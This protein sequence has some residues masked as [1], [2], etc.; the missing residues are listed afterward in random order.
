MRPRPVIILGMHRSGTSCL[1]GSLEARGLYLGDVDRKP[2]TN[3]KGNREKMAL[4]TLNNDVLAGTGATWDRPPMG[5]VVW[6]REQQRRRDAICASF[7][8]GRV[9]GFKDPRTLLLIEGWLASLPEAWLIGTVRN[10]VA[11]ARSL[12]KRNGFPF[13]KSFDL[14]LAYNRRLLDLCR[15]REVSMISFDAGPEVYDARIEALA[16][17]IGLPEG[18][19]GE[20]GS[21]FEAG[22]RTNGHD[23][24]MELPKEVRET[25]AAL[26]ALARKQS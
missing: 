25:H 26:E 13:E 20:T 23:T 12:E 8:A 11:V 6:S 16:R 4:M 24:T 14:W 10:P 18:E 7:P 15:R 1:T 3:P 9:W 22:L 19:A 21:F 17:M 2:H 5:A